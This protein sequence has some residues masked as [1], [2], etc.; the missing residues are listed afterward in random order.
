[1][2]KDE[3]V[4]LINSIVSDS[5]K[6]MD[7]YCDIEDVHVN[8]A[9]IF[10]QNEKEEMEFNSLAG[11][12]GSII[13]D[14]QTGPLYKIRPLETRFGRLQLLKVRSVDQT[15]PERGDADFTITNFDQFWNENKG[16]PQFKLIEREDFVMIELM[17]ESFDVRTYFSNPPLDVQ[18]GLV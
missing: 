2:N 6:L 1:M 18:H 8:Y 16:R 3:F 10:C 4:N 12:L 7:K 13:E 15:R 5:K 17:D 11:E 14:T 9:C